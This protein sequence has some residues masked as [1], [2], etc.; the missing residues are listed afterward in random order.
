[1]PLAWVKARKGEVPSGALVAGRDADGTPLYFARAKLEYSL[2]PGKLKAG[3]KNAVVVTDEGEEHIAR[4]FEVLTGEGVWVEAENGTVPRGA[5]KGGQDD[6]EYAQYL[7][8]AEHEGGVIPGRLASLRG[9][10]VIGAVDGSHVVCSKYRVLIP[11]DLPPLGPDLLES[12]TDDSVYELRAMAEEDQD[13]ISDDPNQTAW[14]KVGRGDHVHRLLLVGPA[15]NLLHLCLTGGDHF[16]HVAYPEGQ[17]MIGY[18]EYRDDVADDPNVDRTKPVVTDLERHGGVRDWVGWTP[19]MFT[20]SISVALNEIK[21]PEL[22]ERLD[23]L[24]AALKTEEVGL[25]EIWEQFT[26]LKAFW[27]KVVS[28]SLFV[29]SRVRVRIPPLEVPPFEQPTP[30]VPTPEEA[31]RLDPSKLAPVAACINSFGEKPNHPDNEWPFNILSLRTVAYGSGKLARDCDSVSHDYDQDDLALAWRLAR[32][33]AVSLNRSPVRYP[34]AGDFFPFVLPAER[35]TAGPSEPTEAFIRAAFGGTINPWARIVIGDASNFDLRAGIEAANAFGWT[36]SDARINWVIWDEWDKWLA[37]EPGYAWRGFINL[38][39]GLAGSRELYFVGG[40]TT[41][42][43]IAGVATVSLGMGLGEDT[44]AKEIRQMHLDHGLSGP[45]WKK[46]KASGRV[47][48]TAIEP[49]EL[50]RWF[51]ETW[52]VNNQY[53]SSDTSR[54]WRVRFR[55]LPVAI[56]LWLDS[57]WEAVYRCLQG[58]WP[59][60]SSLESSIELFS[61]EMCGGD[62]SRHAFYQCSPESVKLV[63]ERLSPRDADWFSNRY[64]D[65]RATDY[66]PRRSGT[67][68][69]VALQAFEAAREFYLSAASRGLAIVSQMTLMTD[70]EL[71]AEQLPPVRKRSAKRRRS[72]DDDGE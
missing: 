62:D 26:Q 38:H 56:D 41:G 23:A 55:D 48:L 64:A 47:H 11:A 12:V 21:K 45:C 58:G 49:G 2:L 70:E 66:A 52:S 65:L 34:R 37:A 57:G 43:T 69:A 22:R 60:E 27:K 50:E 33:A 72:E 59:I 71:S 3:E 17:A 7:A 25:A 10:V 67:D 32:E 4:V 1:M 24:P 19:S 44:T 42:G 15:A 68:L 40:I 54:L 36:G 51:E 6:N 16:P 53:S 30:W 61:H 14:Q 31:A 8:V 5:V 18:D 46:G 39:G 28:E 63:A 9:G 35:G 29:I 13:W 20:D